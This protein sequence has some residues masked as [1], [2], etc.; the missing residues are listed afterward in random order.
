MYLQP[1][2]LSYGLKRHM[3]F[4]N[5]EVNQI[6]HHAVNPKVHPNDDNMKMPNP[7]SSKYYL[8][9]DT[10]FKRDVY[11]SKQSTPSVGYDDFQP[12][13][14]ETIANRDVNVMYYKQ[15][16]NNVPKMGRMVRSP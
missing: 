16:I 6:D 7:K 2:T 3:D 14:S 9:N 12:M 8:Q 11:N 5:I 1:S 13:L 15:N 4:L 10:S